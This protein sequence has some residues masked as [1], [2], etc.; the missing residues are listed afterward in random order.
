M[1]SGTWFALSSCTKFVSKF[2]LFTAELYKC[3]LGSRVFVLFAW[4]N[5]DAAFLHKYASL[6]SAPPDWMRQRISINIINKSIK[7]FL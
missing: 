7:N 4:M 3:A 2:L 1:L 5:R 6:N